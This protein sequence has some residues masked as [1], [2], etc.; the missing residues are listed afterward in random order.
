VAKL[1]AGW[2]RN[3]DAKRATELGFTA[4]K[5]FDEIIAAHVADELGGKIG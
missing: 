5:N 2:P 1:V 3:F 4:E